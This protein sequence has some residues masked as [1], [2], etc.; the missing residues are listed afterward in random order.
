MTTVLIAD[1]HGAVR[2]GIRLLLDTADGISVV[3][4]AADGRTAVSMAD[5]LRPDIVLM[6]VRMP[7]LDGVAATRQLR[8][9]PGGPTVLI[10]TSF[11][12]DDIIL[13]ALRAGAAGFLL[14]SASAEELIGAVHRAAAGDTVLSPEVTASVV[15][16]LSALP[17]E[18]APAAVLPDDLTDR[19][20]EV[21]AGI[22]AGRNN[23]ALAKQLGI[24]EATVKTH[25]SRVLVKLGV[26]SRVQAALA[27]TA[28]TGPAADK[29]G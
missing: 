25:V 23:R 21:L 8:S 17:E 3:G 26:E 19:E 16:M 1:D 10:L 28:A 2:A 6:D 20:R 12:L 15:T 14:K 22:A 7:V 9:A 29:S 11:G 18:P 5:A 13:A 24:T 27:Y 4:E